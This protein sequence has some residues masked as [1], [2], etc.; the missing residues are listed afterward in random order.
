MDIR[1]NL[2]WQIWVDTGGTFTDCLALDPSGKLHKA[3]VLSS[4]ALRGTIENIISPNKFRVIV[5][6]STPVDFIRGFQFCLLETDHPET[7][8]TH[9]N[10]SA[11]TIELDNPLSCEIPPNTSFEVR[12]PEEAPELAARLVTG[13]S[14]DS[15]LPPILKG[16]HVLREAGR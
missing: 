3:K 8:V 11:S 4:S 1:K 10:P 15:S 12:S 5:K 13:T 6:W 9:Y 14:I 16:L 7:W 2:N